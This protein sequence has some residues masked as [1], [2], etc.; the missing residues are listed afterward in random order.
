MYLISQVDKKSTYA[1]GEFES[2][3]QTLSY[4]ANIISYTSWE[5]Q[6]LHQA[7]GRRVGVHACM[8]CVARP[9]HARESIFLM[10]SCDACMHAWTRSI[11]AMLRRN[12]P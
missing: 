11:R 12:T 2:D 5:W 6:P 1:S 9:A 10:N 7:M 3:S 4:C 8:C